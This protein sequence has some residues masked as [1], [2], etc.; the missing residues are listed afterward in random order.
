MRGHPARFAYRVS[1]LFLIALGLWSLD[2]LWV[3]DVQAIPF[4]STSSVDVFLVDQVGGGPG[5]SVGDVKFGPPDE[6]LIDLS[7]SEVLTTNKTFFGVSSL[8]AF[9]NTDGGLFTQGV[10]QVD[11][12][13]S[14]VGLS[15]TSLAAGHANLQLEFTSAD[16]PL[17]LDLSGVF[18]CSGAMGPLATGHVFFFCSPN[19]LDPVCMGFDEFGGYYGSQAGDFPFE[20][21]AILPPGAQ[22]YTFQSVLRVISSAITSP[23]RPPA[24]V[25]LSGTFRLGESLGPLRSF[26]LGSASLRWLSPIGDGVSWLRPGEAAACRSLRTR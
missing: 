23:R 25:G 20:L 16:S 18:H 7:L 21:H 8:T 9:V 15:P 1:V 26:S 5:E 10:A 6:P 22:R 4:T 19:G 11:T 12:L 2:L 3:A 14:P 17:E 24:R 13:L